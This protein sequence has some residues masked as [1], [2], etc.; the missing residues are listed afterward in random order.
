MEVKTYTYE[1]VVYHSVYAV[2]K[3]IGDATGIAFGNPQTAEEWKSLGV[4]YE[5]KIEPDPEPYE[6]TPEELAQ[7]ELDRAKAERAEAVRNIKV[8]VD[9]M[10]FDGDEE[11]QSRMTRAI[12]VAEIK[13]LT[14]TEWVL[15]NNEVAV[16]TL[17]QMKEALSQAM[18]KMSELWTLPYEQVKKA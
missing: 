9:G 6:P 14:Q 2:R 3:A 12:Q 11:A 15:A 18:L 8:T 1:G 10:V 4:T 16:V 7:Q 5:V 17:A 13:G